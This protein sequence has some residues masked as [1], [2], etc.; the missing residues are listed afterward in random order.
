MG[1]GNSV[2]TFFLSVL[3]IVGQLIF[4]GSKGYS[5]RFFQVECKSVSKSHELIFAKPKA[6]AVGSFADEFEIIQLS[7]KKVHQKS[8]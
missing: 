5:I 7:L 3:L 8:R 4:D 6:L 1:F 2:I